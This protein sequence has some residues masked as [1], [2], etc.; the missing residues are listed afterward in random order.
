[1]SAREQIKTR[2]TDGIMLIGIDRPEKKNALSFA[3]YNAI[4]DALLAADS[5]PEVKTIL[6]YG[7]SD[8]FSSGND[9]SDFDNLDPDRPAEAMRLLTTLHE[10]RK[11]LIAAVAGLAVGIGTTLLLHCDLV[12]AAPDTRFRLPFVDLGVCA[13][14][15][16]SLFIPATAGH[17]MAS[18]LLLL[19]EFFDTAKAIE[20]GIVNRSV[21]ANQLLDY[22][23]AKAH[24]LA[25][26]PTQALITT[27][28]LLKQSNQQPVAERMQLEFK[29]FC[30][31]LQTPESVAIRQQVLS[32]KKIATMRN[33]R[34]RKN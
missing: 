30:E 28:R 15:G 21:D 31:L 23:L 33:D 9:L 29:H 6:I 27:K 34:T 22:A 1:M 4:S 24:Q 10:L 7:T 25:S 19:G 3:M 12:Y 2:Q 13:E 17:R 16:S 32:Q 20:A 11:P 18:E 5:N 14:G 26:K 8:A